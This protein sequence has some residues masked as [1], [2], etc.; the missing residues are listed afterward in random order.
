MVYILLA[1]GFEEAEALVPA[2][3]LRRA[4]VSVAL[5]AADPAASSVTG[6]HSITV[7]ADTAASGISL[8]PGDMVLL[9]G[10]LGGVEGMARSESAVRLIRAANRPDCWIAAI[11]AAPTLLGTLGLL[12]GRKAVCYPGMEDGLTGGLPCPGQSVVRDGMLITGEGPGA[13]F[14]FGLALVEALCGT[15]TAQQVRHA[16]CYRG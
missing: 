8:Q 10:G 15:Q 5:T 11:C 1:D 2:D 9:P 13:A 3:L 14:S 4:G 12:D 7:Q 6:A 16:A